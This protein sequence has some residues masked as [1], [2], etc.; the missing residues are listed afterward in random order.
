MWWYA[1]IMWGISRLYLKHEFKNKQNRGRD[2]S[3]KNETNCDFITACL[4]I[5]LIS[6]HSII[7][8]LNEK[9]ISTNLN[10]LLKKKRLANLYLDAINGQRMFRKKY[11]RQALR[12]SLRITFLC[13]QSIMIS[14]FTANFYDFL[15]NLVEH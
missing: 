3:Y 1:E 15:S 6:L 9:N 14:L 13:F 12:T 5:D 4:K 2:L 11:F 8:E 7:C 10:V